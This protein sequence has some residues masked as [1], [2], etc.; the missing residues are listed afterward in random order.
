MNDAKNL[1]S[2][3]VMTLVMDRIHFKKSMLLSMRIMRI[4]R[5]AGLTF[6]TKVNVLIGMTHM[7][8]AKTL[9]CG[10]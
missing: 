6:T 2:S 1:L 7:V 8:K 3:T 4:M 9:H 10:F 5:V